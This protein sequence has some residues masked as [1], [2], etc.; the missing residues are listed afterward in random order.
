MIPAAWRKTTRQP[1]VLSNM[2]FITVDDIQ[3]LA[4]T[5]FWQK[6][7]RSSLRHGDTHFETEKTA[8]WS[9]NGTGVSLVN[10]ISL[11]AFMKRKELSYLVHENSE[12]LFIP[13]VDSK[14]LLC[15]LQPHKL[16]E[17]LRW[18]RKVTSSTQKCEGASERKRRGSAESRIR[19]TAMMLTCGD[20][21]GGGV[22]DQWGCWWWWDK[23][24]WWGAPPGCQ[25]WRWSQS[26]WAR[27]EN[28]TGNLK[29]K[30]DLETE[31]DP[32]LS[33]HPIDMWIFEVKSRSEKSDEDSN[34]WS[35]GQICW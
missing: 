34:E 11:K 35:K 2:P 30:V 10:T 9:P 24:R 29:R 23:P 20:G 18:P 1:S 4:M 7:D 22:K 26:Q 19:V 27:R 16:P 5:V 3:C 13:S 28:R 25:L 32:E 31:V 8:F 15:R 21:G 14:A 33:D 6:E 17:V 12:K